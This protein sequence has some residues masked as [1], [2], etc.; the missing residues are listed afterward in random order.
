[1]ISIVKLQYTV[2]LYIF[3]FPIIIHPVLHRDNR[4]KIFYTKKAL[5]F[6]YERSKLFRTQCTFCINMKYYQILLTDILLF[7]FQVLSAE[8]LPV[9]HR[10]STACKRPLSTAIRV[11]PQMS[12]QY[13]CFRKILQRQDHRRVCQRHMGCRSQRTKITCTSRKFRN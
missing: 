3:S 10:M 6:C 1:M 4:F 7:I 2:F 13:S 5:A 12:A 9:L 8:R 11:G